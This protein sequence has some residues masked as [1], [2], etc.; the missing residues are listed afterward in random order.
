MFDVG[1]W[2]NNRCVVPSTLVFFGQKAI[3][4]R[5][6]PKFP[7]VDN[8]VY[9]AKMGALPI[10]PQATNKAIAINRI[11]APITDVSPLDT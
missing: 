7:N 2:V 11:L 6:C 5:F 8:R 10:L 4:A 9:F 3:K 1:L